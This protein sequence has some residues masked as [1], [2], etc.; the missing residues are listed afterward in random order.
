MDRQTVTWTDLQFFGSFSIKF[1]SFLSRDPWWSTI[2]LGKP[3]TA[4]DD[5]EDDLRGHVSL[6]KL[7]TS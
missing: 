7:I 1:D 5:E 3:N 2:S 4:D 6:H